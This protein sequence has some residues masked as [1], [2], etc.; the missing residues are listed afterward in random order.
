MSKLHLLLPWGVGECSVQAKSVWLQ[1]D[2]RKRVI[3][4]GIS[5]VGLTDSAKEK[6]QS[7]LD[8]YVEL[9]AEITA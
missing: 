2:D 7:Y 4:A 8:R 1:K 6:L 9:A 5:F 3:G